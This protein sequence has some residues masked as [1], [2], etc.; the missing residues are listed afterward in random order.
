[1]AR[2]VTV[3]WQTTP[4]VYTLRRLPPSPSWALNKFV[5]RSVLLGVYSV[6]S[7]VKWGISR[8]IR[9]DRKFGNRGG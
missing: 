3:M 6:L 1:M 8:F 7:F 9:A 5:S 4:D 2:R